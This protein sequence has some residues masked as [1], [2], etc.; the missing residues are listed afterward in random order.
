L[1]APAQEGAA[2]GDAIPVAEVVAD[3]AD[4]IPVGLVTELEPDPSPPPDARGAPA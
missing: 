2:P 4:P 1:R 3:E